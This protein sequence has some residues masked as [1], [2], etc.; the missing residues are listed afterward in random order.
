MGRFRIHLAVSLARPDRPEL[1][2][3]RGTHLAWSDSD[4]PREPGR[5][6]A[7][8]PTRRN[9]ARG[10]RAISGDHPP[11]VHVL[12]APAAR[13]RLRNRFLAPTIRPILCDERIPRIHQTW[14]LTTRT[15][16]CVTIPSASRARRRARR[17]KT[18]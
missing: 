4:V 10:A 15:Y 8:P 16:S 9:G 12:F 6:A 7:H 18:P 13:A 3:G 1:R 17:S 2:Q 11:G 5:A 14:S